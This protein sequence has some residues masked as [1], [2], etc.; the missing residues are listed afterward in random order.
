MVV[1]CE[2]CGETIPRFSRACICEKQASPK[3]TKK[4]SKRGRPRKIQSLQKPTPRWKEH[5]RGKNSWGP[6]GT[7]ILWPNFLVPALLERVCLLAQK[8]QKKKQ[9]NGIRS[10]LI[11][12]YVAVPL[13]LRCGWGCDKKKRMKSSS[14]NLCAQD[15][16]IRKYGERK[17][18][19]EILQEAKAL[20]PNAEVRPNIIKELMDNFTETFNGIREIFT[21]SPHSWICVVEGV[22]EQGLTANPNY[23]HVDIN[24]SGWGSDKSWDKSRKLDLKE[25][26]G[27][28]D[29]S[30]ADLAIRETFEESGLHVKLLLERKWIMEYDVL[31][32]QGRK[33]WIYVPTKDPLMSNESIKVQ[34]AILLEKLAELEPVEVRA[35]D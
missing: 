2:K 16:P 23:C 22:T 24:I 30:Q 27:R 29:L 28:E 35:A 10:D 12:A 31:E 21:A 26:T 13:E 18:P 33:V 4:L 17:I 6:A 34:E 25:K 19:P 1:I 3:Q 7:L 14:K 11:D 5:W 32:F 15:C 8:I 20:R 9:E